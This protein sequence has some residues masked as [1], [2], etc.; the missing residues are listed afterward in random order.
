MLPS[1]KVQFL[2]LFET[3]QCQTLFKESSQ[4]ALNAQRNFTRLLAAYFLNYP[5]ISVSKNATKLPNLFEWEQLTKRELLAQGFSDLDRSEL[6]AKLT[7]DFCPKAVVLLLCKCGLQLEAVLYCDHFNDFRS[8]LI[9]RFYTDYS[10]GLSTF[11]SALPTIIEDLIETVESSANLEHSLQSI[12]TSITAHI[13]C[14]VQ[15]SCVFAHELLETTE[16]ALIQQ[17]ELHF[18]SLSEKVPNDVNLPRPPV[19]STPAQYAVKEKHE[20]LT[21]NKMHFY[22]SAFTELLQR[23]N[24]MPELIAHV[25]SQ[26]NAAATTSTDCDLPVIFE[27]AETFGSSYSNLLNVILIVLRVYY[28]DMLTILGDGDADLEEILQEF[29]LSLFPNEDNRTEEELFENFLSNAQEPDLSFVT[30]F[31]HHMKDNYPQNESFL[32]PLTY[33]SLDQWRD[34]LTKNINVLHKTNNTDNLSS[35]MYP[36]KMFLDSAAI[37][38]VNFLETKFLSTSL[39]DPTL[40]QISLRL[41]TQELFDD[42]P[43][44]VSGQIGHD[45]TE[46]EILND[47]QQMVKNE[48]VKNASPVS[49]KTVPTIDLDEF[50]LELQREKKFIES[51]PKVEPFVPPVSYRVPL[52]IQCD[53]VIR[54]IAPSNFDTINRNLEKELQQLGERLAV[55]RASSPNVPSSRQMNHP[56]SSP[57]TSASSYSSTS[58]SARSRRPKTQSHARL[59]RSRVKELQRSSTSTVTESSDNHLIAVN[60]AVPSARRRD[61]LPTAQL[62]PVPTPPTLEKLNFSLLSPTSPPIGKQ[63]WKQIEVYAQ[64]PKLKKSHATINGADI[65]SLE[66]TTSMMSMDDSYLEKETN[67]SPQMQESLYGAKHRDHELP[68][69]LRLIPPKDD[70]SGRPNTAKFGKLLDMEAALK[71]SARSARPVSMKRHDSGFLEGD[72]TPKKSF[73][74]MSPPPTTAF[75]CSM[76]DDQI[77]ELMHF[78]T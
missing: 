32:P 14:I 21:W 53:P 65:P 3:N 37:E 19:F 73:P 20:L 27:D 4:T 1:T 41:S 64:S 29:Y 11:I 25:L 68:S 50:E 55:L 78:C 18:S 5:I 15:L 62:I 28:R 61:Y 56:T 23:T 7:A 63:T 44:T 57:S 58:V 70:D 77:N 54:K 17:L 42:L 38:K 66:L 45:E 26:V 49:S 74:I 39:A 35:W 72:S 34:M 8:M 13:K 10:L 52:T 2:A 48:K 6:A 76:T 33:E 40:L 24:R 30:V 22:I 36:D 59:E 12:Q 60:E 9:C 69:W 75:A 46:D 51:L 67:K 31:L 71:L 47:N 43:M 16:F